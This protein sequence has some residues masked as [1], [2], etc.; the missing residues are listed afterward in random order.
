M[1]GTAQVFFAGWLAEAWAEEQNKSEGV[2]VPTNAVVQRRWP[3]VSVSAG[4][5][6]RRKLAEQ[7][8]AWAT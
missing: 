1:A 5:R 4:D 6:P 2:A 3:G 8:R 7:Q